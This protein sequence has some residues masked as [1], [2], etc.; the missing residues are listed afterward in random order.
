MKYLMAID[1]GTGSVRAVIFDTKGNQ[2]AIEQKVWEHL[3]EPNIPNSMGFDFEK[4]WSLTFDCIKNVIKKSGIDSND[5]VAIS[6]SS[7]REG[8]V[9]YDKNNKE[10]WGVANVDAR[11]AQEVKELKDNFQNIEKEFY[12]KTGQTL[13]LGAIPR[14]LWLKKYK[15]DI[16]DNVASVSMI[17]DWI[18]FKLSGIISVEPS[19]ASTTGI[20]N[21]KK[22][23][24]EKEFALKVGLKNNIFPKVYE[25]GEAIGLISKNIAQKLNLSY[26]VKIVSGGG[27]VQIGSLGLGVISSGQVAI[28]GGSF[29]QQIVNIPLDTNPPLDMDIRVNSHVLKDLSQA[30]GI[31][32]FSG[33]VM[34]WFVDAFCD[35]EKIEAKEQ[36]CDVY[37]ILENKASKVPVGSYDIMPIFSHSMNYAKWYHAAPSFINLNIDPNICNKASIFRSLEENAAIVSYINLQKVQKFTNMKFDTIIFASGASKGELWCQILAD[38]TGM[39]IKVPVVKEA[40]SLGCAI[41][42]GVAAGIYNSLEEGAKELVKWEKTYIPNMDNHILYQKLTVKWEKIYKSQLELVDKNLTTSMWKAPGL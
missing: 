29:W 21:L 9:V 28:L 17:S 27:D 30:E 6:S 25:T 38:V 41:A 22:R 7:M 40:T 12:E 5:I 32:F 3:S 23:S 11:A 18:L 39:N 20:L 19:N 42:A 35:M 31:T 14:L 8:I 34:R 36:G 33:L 10:L 13:A 16:Y 26:L 15:K 24:W 4:N 2:I 1:A 37:N